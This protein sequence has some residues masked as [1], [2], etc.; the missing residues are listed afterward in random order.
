[1]SASSWSLSCHFYFTSYAIESAAHRGGSFLYSPV[2]ISLFS[3]SYTCAHLLYRLEQENRDEIDQIPA[4]VL[5]QRGW[6]SKN[7]IVRE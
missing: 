5:Y 1:M 4:D 3:M 7:D 6:F 2:D